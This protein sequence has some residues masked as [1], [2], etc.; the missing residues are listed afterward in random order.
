[1]NTGASLAGLDEAKER[2]LHFQRKLHDWASEDA[3]RGFCDLWNLVCDEA[4]LLVAWSRVSANR[5]SRT[6][7]IDSF[8]C[9]RVER[10]LGPERFL[11]EL[12]AELKQGRFRP[13]PVRER[14]IP[15]RD[16]NR[17]RLGIPTVKD[18]VVQMALKLVLEPLFESGFY[19]S[20]YGYRPG[21]R[22]HDAIAEIV[23]FAHAPSDYEW[24]IEADIEACFDRIDHARLMAEVAR[25]VSDKRVLRLVRSFLKAGMMTETGRLERSVT[26]TPQGGIISPLLA[27]IALSGLD[28]GYQADW[29]EMSR[30]TGRRQYLRSRGQPTWRLVRF[31]DDLVVVVKGTEA[32]AQALLEQLAGR[33]E[34]IGLK[35]KPEKTGVTHIDAGFVFLG[36]RIIRLPKGPKRHV[37]TFVCDEALASIKRRI[38]ALT[39]RSTTYLELADLLRTINPILRGWAGYFRYASAKRTFAY[40][41]NYAWWRVMRW[42]RK[43]HPKRT[44]RQLRRRYFGAGGI[45]EK[46]V[47][48]YNPAAMRVERYR[49]RGALISTPWNEQTVDPTGGR[50][51][52]TRHDDPRSLEA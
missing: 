1:M 8:S 36:Q 27:N 29:Q 35:L 47:T 12:R 42:L 43:K 15:K 38:K 17:R 19:P 13:A 40:L 48:L 31:A 21:R 28:R 26:G 39:G 4:T 46:G 20:S 5:G 2:V 10:E 9:H 11:S 52:R 51:R 25:R 3:E 41:G 16:G 50:F 7:G 30:Y 45:Q 49:Y 18:R 24:V 37:Y 44:W 22:A 6:A 33:V 34:A 14:Q 32:Q 23:H